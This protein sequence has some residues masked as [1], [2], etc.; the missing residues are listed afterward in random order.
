M[1]RPIGARL[2]PARR[3]Y[4]GRAHASIRRH[5]TSV[6]ALK[7]AGGWSTATRAYR[8][9][10][11]GPS[12][13]TSLRAK[14][15]TCQSLSMAD[16]GRGEWA[17]ML[18]ASHH[19]IPQHFR[20]E[21]RARALPSRTLQRSRPLRPGTSIAHSASVH[22]RAFLPRAVPSSAQ[23]PAVAFA[24]DCFD[25]TVYLARRFGVETSLANEVLGSWLSHQ[26]EGEQS[27]MIDRSPIGAS[28]RTVR[29]DDAHPSGVSSAARLCS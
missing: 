1:R 12:R 28:Q 11:L 21:Q 14:H 3:R 9:R 18:C 23:P 22:P 20:F 26:D 13:W 17:R 5:P 16:R 6:V 25:F 4:R 10:D 2:P 7:E 19:R 8:T 24:P 29:R 27:S 15:R